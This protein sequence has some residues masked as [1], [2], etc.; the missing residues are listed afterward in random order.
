M[1]IIR[2]TFTAKPGS[3]SK[4]AKLMKDSTSDLPAKVRV[5][6]DLVGNM[7]TVI[8]EMEVKDIGEFERM[9]KDYSDTPDRREKM[10]GYT[11]MYEQGKREIYQIL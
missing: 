10:K 4:L 3:A 7:N 8:M 6:T 5:M 11:D 9:M 1:L 2:N